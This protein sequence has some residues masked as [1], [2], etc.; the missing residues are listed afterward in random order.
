MG[1][2]NG[3]VPKGLHPLAKLIFFSFLC[4]VFV[5]VWKDFV[6]YIRI[7]ISFEYMR[8][9]IDDVSTYAQKKFT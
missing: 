8:S 6:E 7:Q 4:D 3:K 9:E 1:M 2:Y 5:E